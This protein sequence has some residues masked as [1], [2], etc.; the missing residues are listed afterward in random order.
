MK[1]LRVGFGVG[2]L[3]G[4]VFAVS[5]VAVAAW[6]SPEQSTLEQTAHNYVHGGLVNTADLPPFMSAVGPNGCILVDEQGEPVR[7]PTGGPSPSQASTE[8]G[9]TGVR[10]ATNPDEVIVPTHRPAGTEDC[11]LDRE[12]VARSFFDGYPIGELIKREFAEARED[13]DWPD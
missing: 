5:S 3:A 9:G 7:V 12:A 13:P 1:A 11:S 8:S 2:A 10:S 4:I 6:S